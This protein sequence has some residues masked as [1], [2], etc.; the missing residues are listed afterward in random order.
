MP[1]RIYK[2]A[3]ASVRFFG[4]DLDPLTITR[5]LELPPDLQHRN[6]EPRLS[7]SSKGRVIRYDEYR[8]GLWSMSSK[9]WVESPRLENHLDWLLSQLEPRSETVGALLSGAVAADFFCY[10]S[11]SSP[12]PRSLSGAIRDRAESLGISIEIDHYHVASPDSL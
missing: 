11:G 12:E 1:K 9:S 6:G 5:A 4:P 8:A 3:Y 10:T 7:R 2:R